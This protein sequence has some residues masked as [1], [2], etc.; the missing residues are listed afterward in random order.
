M[1]GCL[2]AEEMDALEGRGEMF[3]CPACCIRKKVPFYVS[4]KIIWSVGRMTYMY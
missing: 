1:Q 2:N 4:E 3:V